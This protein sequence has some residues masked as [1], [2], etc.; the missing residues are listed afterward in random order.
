MTV[1]YILP[2]VLN[3]APFPQATSSQARSGW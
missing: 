2:L 3:R 1:R